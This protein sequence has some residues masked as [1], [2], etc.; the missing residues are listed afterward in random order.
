M[1]EADLCGQSGAD[2]TSA[3]FLG[4]FLVFVSA[5]LFVNA[6]ALAKAF[7]QQPPRLTKHNEQS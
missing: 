5:D 7:A 2:I 1:I 4:L 6:K 3:V